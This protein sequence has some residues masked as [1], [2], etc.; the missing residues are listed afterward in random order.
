MSHAQPQA[1]AS[2]FDPTTPASVRL[3]AGYQFTHGLSADG[4]EF[5][6]HFEPET[7]REFWIERET[8]PEARDE[9]RRTW[10]AYAGEAP[11]GRRRRAEVL[12]TA[13]TRGDQIL[14][15]GSLYHLDAHNPEALLHGLARLIASGEWPREARWERL[16]IIT[17]GSPD[18]WRQP[19][20]LDSLFERLRTETL[21]PE[22]A[23][24]EGPLFTRLPNYSFR[25]W[26]RFLGVGA[27]FDVRGPLEEMRPLGRALK[28]AQ[29]TPAYL[30]ALER[31]R[32]RKTRHRNA[33]G[34]DAD[35]AS[36]RSPAPG[37][38]SA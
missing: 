1:Q 30:S 11:P 31:Y 27:D 19:D 32:E 37:E 22:P 35:R 2:L 21:D 13:L 15:C 5:Y 17:N 14:R 36:E 4:K 12:N 8:N 9:I 7:G 33:G 29:K 23:E 34:T 20:P 28:A 3:V 24:R 16:T 6:T 10:F 18:Q 38:T 26:G 25:A